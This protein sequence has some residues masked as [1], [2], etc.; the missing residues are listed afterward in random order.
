MSCMN[1]G[2]SLM[3][4]IFHSFHFSS[5]GGRQFLSCKEVSAYLQSYFGGLH[6]APLTMD[7]GGDIALQ[8][9]QLASENVSEV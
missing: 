8:G 7:K 5:P 3:N 4:Y 1:F 6:D 9:H 2:L